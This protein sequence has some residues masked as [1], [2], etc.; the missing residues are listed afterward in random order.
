MLSNRLCTRIL[1][2]KSRGNRDGRG[3]GGYKV[4]WPRRWR[5]ARTSRRDES[6]LGSLLLKSIKNGLV[7]RVDETTII[8]ALQIV[9]VSRTQPLGSVVKSVTEWFVNAFEC[10][11]LGHE[12]LAGN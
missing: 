5:N 3:V 8:T 2:Q 6:D 1:E 10:I 12:D 11:A 9:F 7:G 4:C